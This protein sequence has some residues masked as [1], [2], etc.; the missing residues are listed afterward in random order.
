MTATSEEIMPPNEWHNLPASKVA[1]HLDTNLQ[2]GLTSDEVV[3]RRERFGANE[4]QAKSGTNPILRFLLQ[5][6]QPLLYILL[7]AGAIKAL[8]GQ[9]VN[10][11]VIWGV[12]LINA[13]IG[14]IQ[15][16]K[17]ESA[18]AALA[19]SVQT[20]ATILRNNQKLQVPSTEL[21]PGDLV[22]L[23]SGDKV[24]AD[25]RLIQSRNLQVNESALTGESVAI[26]K[27]TEPL[28]A[29]APLAERSN[30]AYAGSFVTF[31]TGK[32]IVVAIGEE[33]E[34][35]RISQLMEQGTSLKTPLTRKFDKFSRTL[36]YIILGIAALTFAVG[37]G[38]GNSWA[39]MFEAAVAFAVS[40]IPEGLPAVVTVTLAI[41][42][43]RMARRHA[44]VRKLP[45]VETLGGATVICSDKTGTLTENQMTVQ[46]IYAGGEQYTVTGTGYA[47][48]GEILCDEQPINGQDFPVLTE[49]LKAGLLCNDSHLEQ[50]EGE[51]QVVGDPTEGGLIVV[52]D[53][54]GL[55]RH[56]LEIEMPRLDAI[57]FESEFQY[58]ATLHEDRSQKNSA[59]V[60]TVY[61]KG[62]VEAILQRCQQMLDTEG[63]AI[64][65]NP[66]IIHQEV[67][68]MANFG[69]RVLAFAKKSLAN[70]QNSLNRADIEKDLVFLGLQ[71]MIDPP[72][73]EAI[74]AVA[75]C[76]NAGIQVKMITG[77]HAATAKAIAQSMGFN[78]N[79][80]V[81]A[82][83]GK[84]LAQMDNSQLTTAIEDGVV[85]ARVAPEQKLRIVEAL[86]SKGEVVAMT[87]DG[88]NDAPALKQADIG[89]AMGGAGTEVAKEAA[90]MILTDD[91]FASIEAAVEEGRTVYR[92]LLKAIAFILP[93]NGG[94]SMTILISVLFA[95]ELPILSLQVLW[96]N[97]VNSIAMTVPL[98]FE[99]KSQRVMQQPPRSPR[100]PLL[101]QSL[102]K[103][104][105]AISIFNWILIFGVFEWIQQTTGNTDLARTMAIQA[106]VAGRVIYL[107]SISKLG[108][109][110]INKLRGVKEK[111]TNVSAMAIG[112][113]ATIILQII[114]SQWNIM[115]SLFSTAPLNLTQ[116]LICL[117]IGLPMILVATLVNRFDPLN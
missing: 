97:M 117:L 37:L 13:I 109:L 8:I 49:C 82:F 70:G 67:D 47:P 116:W 52:A 104:I 55:H 9:W 32:G 59:S 26:E 85:F 99:P 94:E 93:V 100:E 7:I 89:I 81:L 74:K 87:G 111:F 88:V 102:I 115:N 4:L 3:K 107:L 96:L 22:L 83:T 36:L 78:K 39:S 106:L 108:I 16:S 113:A 25:L 45:A 79:G 24:P 19:S 62:S 53:K 41:G 20:N 91:N 40:A 64:A 11:W 1:Q 51:W 31:G 6:N 30:M 110:L 50:K 44:I 76:Q 86:Q 54:V 5:F 58:M 80:E 105:L 101:S 98:A 112:I 28:E 60:R 21:V 71:G 33:T 72:R 38:Y 84:E 73:T 35:G 23:T 66:E 43:S 42:V 48:E 57:P 90:D 56:N 34:T 95:R 69:L 75:A 17:A 61:V 68:V 114:F 10:A 15:E 46:A 103:R 92:N 63:K 14:F 77:D 29:D 65:L 27:N 18:I 12:T 2:T